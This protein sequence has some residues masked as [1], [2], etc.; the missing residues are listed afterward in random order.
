MNLL[1]YS[2]HSCCIQPGVSWRQANL[3]LPWLEIIYFFFF[4]FPRNSSIT[5]CV[6]SSRCCFPPGRNGVSPAWAPLAGGRCKP[7]KRWL[8]AGCWWSVGVWDRPVSP[9][10]FSI[11]GLWP[12]LPCAGHDRASLF[13]AVKI[14]TEY[15][16]QYIL[17]VRSLES[18]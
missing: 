10:V 4:A 12:P 7:K 8:W 3:V 18:H 6:I 17:L 11:K 15:D 9:C 2:H 14:N 16:R 5:C 13:F 1:Y